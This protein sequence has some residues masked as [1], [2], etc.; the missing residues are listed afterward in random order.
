[1]KRRTLFMMILSTAVMTLFGCGGGGGGGD[2]VGP[3]VLPTDS[4]ISGVATAGPVIGG[5]VQ[6]FAVAADGTVGVSA[7]KTGTT[8]LDGSYNINMGTFTGAVLVKVTG[9]SY[10]DEATQTTKNLATEAG[11]GMRSVIAG[12][13]AGTTTVVITPL[14]E[15]AVQK[16]G[17]TLTVAN[18]N[19]A[20]T[21]VGNF[22]KI[23]NIVSTV[24]FDATVAPPASATTEQKAYSVAVAAVSQLQSI[25]AT[26]LGAL[27]TTVFTEMT[28]SGGMSAAMLNDINTATTSFLNSTNN[29]TG[30]TAATVPVI[31]PSAGILKLSTDGNLGAS[32]IGAIDVTVTLPAGVTIKTATGG[33][34]PLAGVVTVSGVAAAASGATISAT[35]YTPPA[36]ATP[37]S[38]RFVIGNTAT[39]VG[40]PSGFSL[41][42]F[43]TINCDLA[44][45]ADF[46]SADKFLFPSLTVF[47]GQGTSAANLTGITVVPTFG[48]VVQ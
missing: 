9:G 32:L 36:G 43:V 12:V 31:K 22:F 47:E 1:M 20:N 26:T 19:K 40:A 23:A 33:N 18:I 11:S 5:T 44:A 37:A 42:N 46:P 48:A 2:V 6:V 14:T 41:G 25:K 15:L 16:A 29:K 35:N 27:L 39:V 38:L 30:L 28:A 7:L 4:V 34:E 10:R 3:I 8:G 24:P 45:N 17:A 13:A 21:D